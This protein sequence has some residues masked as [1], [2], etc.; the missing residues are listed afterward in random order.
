MNPKSGSIYEEQIILELN[1]IIMPCVYLS[2][3]H[4][5]NKHTREINKVMKGASGTEGTPG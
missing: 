4:Q 5:G 1:N 3:R 2:L